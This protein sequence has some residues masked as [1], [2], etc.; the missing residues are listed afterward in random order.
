M[1]DII[2]IPPSPPAGSVIAVAVGL[3]IIGTVALVRY[4][5]RLAVIES[6]LA[7][8]RSKK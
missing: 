5:A 3:V 8:R 6:E 1:I 2:P 4:E 7:A